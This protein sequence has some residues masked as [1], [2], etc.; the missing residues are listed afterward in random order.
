MQA[1]K[2]T[3]PGVPDLYQGTELED[4]SLVDPDNRRP[5]DF[6]ERRRLLAE[7][8]HPKLRL[9]RAALHARPSGAYAPLIAAGEAASHVLG[10]TRGGRVATIVPLR[11]LGLARRGGYGET[12]VDLPR[13]LWTN[14]VTDDTVR[15]GTVAVEAVLDGFP[16]AVLVRVED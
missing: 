6:D 16:V 13:G 2:L 9:T 4:L 3:A 12:T 7:G 11:P 5:V 14:A 1:L 10:F 15:G 8:T